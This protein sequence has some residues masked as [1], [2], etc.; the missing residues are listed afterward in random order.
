MQKELLYHQITNKKLLRKEYVRRIILQVM[1]M[2]RHE[3]L[4]WKHAQNSLCVYDELILIQH[5]GNYFADSKMNS[6]QGLIDLVLNNL[7]THNWSSNSPE[8]TFV[9]LEDPSHQPEN[10]KHR[11]CRKYMCY[12]WC[13][14]ITEGGRKDTCGPYDSS[15]GLPAFI[16]SV[17]L[18]MRVREWK[19]ACML[20]WHEW[21]K[22]LPDM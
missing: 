2:Y 10:E 14:Y 8:V 3:I 18:R 13:Q 16:Y 12:T 5:Q 20:G 6:W 9:S 11:Q 7:N 15:I 17:D 4:L 19:Y 1:I 22:K 21:L